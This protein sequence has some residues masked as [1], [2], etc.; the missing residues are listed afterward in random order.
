MADISGQIIAKI[1]NNNGNILNFTHGDYFQIFRPSNNDSNLYLYNEYPTYKINGISGN[2]DIFTIK[3]NNVIIAIGK[4]IDQQY[5]APDAF[6]IDQDITTIFN[7]VQPQTTESAIINRITFTFFDTWKIVVPYSVPKNFEVSLSPVIDTNSQTGAYVKNA[8]DV[9]I[10]MIDNGGL[11]INDFIY[12]VYDIN[13]TTSQFNSAVNPPKF[14]DNRYTFPLYIP[15]NIT[16]IEIAAKNIL[17][18]SEKVIISYDAPIFDLIPGNDNFDIVITKDSQFSYI[19][20]YDITIGQ[21]LISDIPKKNDFV[22]IDNTI[23][24]IVNNNNNN[25]IVVSNDTNYD[26]SVVANHLLFGKS[27]SITKSVTP[28]TLP[29]KPDIMLDG[30]N[31]S[32][33]V[34]I[35][36]TTFNYV[37]GYEYAFYV[38]QDAQNTIFVP[39]NDF[40]YETINNK[41]YIKKV[42]TVTKGETLYI[43]VKIKNDL[44]YSE[45]V[46]GNKKVELVG[47][48]PVIDVITGDKNVRINITNADDLQKGDYKYN[49]FIIFT[50]VAGI[51]VAN[52]Y[53]PDSQ[54]DIDN[55]QNGI[56][57]TI[58]ITAL[59]N[60]GSTDSN[61]V[62]VTP[63]GKP[64]IVTVAFGPTL[65]G[66]IVYI[67]PSIETQNGSP[68]ISYNLKASG[69]S[70][71]YQLEIPAT[72]LKSSE[73]RFI[74]VV[75]KFGDN[76]P[77]INNIIYSVKINAKNSV[78]DGDYSDAV[79]IT[80]KYTIPIIN[81][82]STVDYTGFDKN[83]YIVKFGISINYGLNYGLQ[84]NSIIS[85]T[86]KYTLNGITKSGVVEY[87]FDDNK[88]IFYVSMNLLFGKTYR[89]SFRASN[90]NGPSLE[91]T[92]KENIVYYNV[93]LSNNITSNTSEPSTNSSYYTA[94]SVFLALSNCINNNNYS[95]DYIKKIMDNYVN[96]NNSIPKEDLLL[97]FSELLK[98]DLRN[99]N[100]IEQ[101][102][103]FA[104]NDE[105]QVLIA[106]LLHN[107]FDGIIIP[108]NKNIYSSAILFTSVVPGTP[109]NVNTK[110][111]ACEYT[112]NQTS[113]VLD[114]NTTFNI[115]YYA[116]TTIGNMTEALFFSIPNNAALLIKNDKNNDSTTIFKI[117]NIVYNY[118]EITKEVKE[119]DVHS[120][121]LS[122]KVGDYILNLK[123][124]GSAAFELVGLTQPLC[125]HPDMIIDELGM[126]ISSVISHPFDDSYVTNLKLGFTNKFVLFP[127][128]S[129]GC[130]VP[131]ADLLITPEHPILYNNVEIKAKDFV[132]KNNIRIVHTDDC[133]PIYSLAYNIRKSIKIHN[134]DVMQWKYSDFVEYCDNKNIS[135][136]SDTGTTKKY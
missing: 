86:Y 95:A 124:V 131:S 75:D 110:Y 105:A 133:L 55:L 45:E 22:D 43:S 13:G 127:T 58:Y 51:K 23:K 76:S 24:Y 68:I 96:F 94:D 52:E 77:V 50:I 59:S 122:I 120:E 63:M 10:I 42:F 8:A 98:N 100:T 136:R 2:N 30:S 101:K 83:T 61:V 25:N 57:I 70:T 109:N 80:P 48:A 106:N 84:S 97:N 38:E 21:I 60:Q 49:K 115:K 31:D 56:P 92:Y 91:F 74:Y 85:I 73:G 134:V 112:I 132:G 104:N 46:F 14:G 53:D 116:T 72:K 129:L 111:V 33:F 6:F 67:T 108:Y 40:D 78:G 113:Y 39:I 36:P 12:S 20:S 47:I 99:D 16:K 41:Q 69:N 37:T 107:N 128:N 66:I 135:Y 119:L 88:Q 93:Q 62:T 79:D 44:G 17:G 71:I 117:N 118:N 130:N 65:N 7:F 126:P 125:I 32:I 54:F 64:K 3:I 29:G 4:Y 123:A 114:A 81:G 28:H 26:V 90:N 18:L 9:N 34:Y 1:N 102:S 15:D 35:L 121:N 89:M 11:E 82:I 87:V 19:D 5:N 27:R 103:L